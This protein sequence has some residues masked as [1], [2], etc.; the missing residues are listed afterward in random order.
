MESKNIAKYYT[1]HGDEAP[2]TQCGYSACCALSVAQVCFGRDRTYCAVHT[3]VVDKTQSEHYSSVCPTSLSCITS[4]ALLNIFAACIL[5]C[6]MLVGICVAEKNS[7]TDI[8]GNSIIGAGTAEI[9]D[10]VD[11]VGNINSLNG[12]AGNIAKVTEHN[13]H[14]DDNVFGTLDDS[15]LDDD[16]VDDDNDSPHVSSPPATVHTQKTNGAN[17]VENIAIQR[18]MEMKILRNPN[19]NGEEHDGH[20]YNAVKILVINTKNGKKHIFTIRNNRAGDKNHESPNSNKIKL[21]NLNL[22]A[23]LSVCWSEATGVLFPE[24]KALLE[25]HDIDGHKKIFSGWM[26]ASNPSVSQPFYK[27]YIFSIMTCVR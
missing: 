8:G 7:L 2:L 11:S 13:I 26:F 5:N 25:I 16:N 12:N 27:Q 20:F 4:T 14:Q 1:D 10:N 22:D 23:K 15:N 6:F 17:D 19:S 24:S 18:I 9:V 3:T 21:E